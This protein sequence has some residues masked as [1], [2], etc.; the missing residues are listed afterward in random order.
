MIFIIDVTYP[1]LNEK[2]ILNITN[3]EVVKSEL[4]GVISTT[5]NDPG[6]IDDKIIAYSKEIEK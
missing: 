3:P 6:P 5:N 2:N 4:D 1:I